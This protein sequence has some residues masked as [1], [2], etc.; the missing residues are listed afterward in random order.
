VIATSTMMPAPVMHPRNGGDVARLLD[1]LRGEAAREVGAVFLDVSGKRISGAGLPG[2]TRNSVSRALHGCDSNPLWR[3]A[4]WFVLARRLGIP[5]ARLQRAIGWLQ[6][7]LDE[8]YGDVPRAT[9]AEVLEQDAA[10]DGKDDLPRQKAARRDRRALVELV[11]AEAEQMAASR[12][13][14]LTVRGWLAE[15]G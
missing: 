9:L 7:R 11:E 4:G 8:A 12:T 5:K 3:L 14:I 10:A 1:S 15:Q 2:V 13:L 6:S